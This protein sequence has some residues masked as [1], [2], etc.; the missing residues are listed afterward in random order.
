MQLDLSK[1][2]KTTFFFGSASRSIGSRSSTW[3]TESVSARS[4]GQFA[5]ASP[6]KEAHSL[7]PPAI[8]I[9]FSLHTT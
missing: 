8:T 7:Y 3:S 5:I 2:V 9:Y 4:A 6:A 1:R